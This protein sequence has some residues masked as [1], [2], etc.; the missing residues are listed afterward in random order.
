MSRRSS[1]WAIL[2]VLALGCEELGNPKQLT[3][4]PTIWRTADHELVTTTHSFRNPKTIQRLVEDG[5]DDL[6]HSDAS[7]GPNETLTFVTVAPRRIRIMK[8]GPIQLVTRFEVP[9]RG[10]IERR[11]RAPASARRWDAAF[12]LPGPPSQAVTSAVP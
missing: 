3:T 7:I 2:V 11:W 4:G 9:D 10:L 1:T 12:A 6:D 8:P 5:L